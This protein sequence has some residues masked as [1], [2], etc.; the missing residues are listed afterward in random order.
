MSNYDSVLRMEGPWFQ[1]VFLNIVDSL[2]PV[3]EFGRCFGGQ[4]TTCIVKRR[5]M[6]TMEAFRYTVIWRNCAPTLKGGVSSPRFVGMSRL[7]LV[8]RDI[9][10]P[11]DL[12]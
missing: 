5:A 6:H 3:S 11:L 2:G 1:Y 4:S 12:L 10:S 9:L 7:V 8:N